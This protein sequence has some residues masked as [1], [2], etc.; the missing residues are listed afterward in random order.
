M[1]SDASTVVIVLFLLAPVLVGILF[2]VFSPRMRSVID[3]RMLTADEQVAFLEA[4]VITLHVEDQRQMSEEFGFRSFLKRTRWRID[5]KKEMAGIRP[6]A[7]R[8]LQNRMDLE[9]YLN[10]IK[11]KISNDTVADAIFSACRDL[12]ESEGISR[13]EGRLLAELERTLRPDSEQVR[14]SEE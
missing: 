12:S 9:A 3:A 5:V 13:I 7:L 14:K 10:G 11:A 2:R 8:A 6:R 1:F 4:A